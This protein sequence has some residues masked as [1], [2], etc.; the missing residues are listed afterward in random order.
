MAIYH[1]S[2][3]IISRGKGQSAVAAAA[4]R[5][6]EEIT[7]DYDGLTHDYTHKNGVVHTEILLPGNAPNEYA[8]R[9][10]LWNAVEMAEKN[11]NAQLA[12]EVEIALPI[13][14]TQEQNLDLAR[15][16]VLDNFV[17]AGMCADICIHDKG[18][19]N[20]HAHIM[21]TMRPLDESGEWIGKQR[22]EYILGTYG[23]KIYDPKKRTVQMPNR[24][25]DRLEQPGQS[26]AMAGGV[27]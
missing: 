12:R 3:K 17:S 4:Y 15:E 7:S 6:G 8:D 9:A 13:E 22:K 27:G 18:D 11:R 10:K 24:A 26:G 23:A 2:I 21:L 1:Y 25:N 5:A 16:Y 19:G 14:L 20:P